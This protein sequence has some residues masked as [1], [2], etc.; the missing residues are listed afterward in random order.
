M[1]RVPP[2]EEVPM[3]HLPILGV[4]LLLAGCLDFEGQDVSVAFDP[5]NDRICM[6]LVY[7][8]LFSSS[9]YS[10][11]WFGKPAPA[12]SMADTERQLREL[13]DGKQTFALLS[14]WMT[15]DLDQLRKSDDLREV[16]LAQRLRVGNGE[17]FVAK[18]GRLC[19]WQSLRLDGAADA[20]TALDSLFRVSVAEELAKADTQKSAAGSPGEDPEGG[21]I[22]IAAARSLGCDDPE[23]ATRWR[24]AL[25]TRVRFFEVV[26]TRVLWHVPAGAAAGSALAERIAKSP[27]LSGICEPGTKAPAPA[28]PGEARREPIA[29]EAARRTGPSDSQLL[30]A[31][32]HDLGATVEPTATGVDVVLLD[33]ARPP[34]RIGF[35]HHDQDEEHGDP[36][37]HLERTKLKVRTDLTDATLKQAFDEFRSR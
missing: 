27:S 28:A 5:K 32:L 30:C 8:G 10:F 26:G 37:Q 15:F 36:I 22:P 29:T 17:L 13:A 33:A 12:D 24:T 20:V 16:A 23:S 14:S 9:S 35:E 6:Q 25:G 1:V 11:S 21:R 19:G 7:R 4:L 34:V 18:D 3:R 31:L 2:S